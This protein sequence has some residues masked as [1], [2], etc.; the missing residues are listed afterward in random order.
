MR[1]KIAA[2]KWSATVAAAI[3]SMTACG[4]IPF[5]ALDTIFVQLI[6]DLFDSLNGHKQYND[7]NKMYRTVLKDGSPQVMEQIIT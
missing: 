6:D 1:V 7:D 2:Q 3:N 4:I 5:A